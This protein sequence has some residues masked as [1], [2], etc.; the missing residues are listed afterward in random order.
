VAEE[1][2]TITEAA[3]RFGVSTDAV[4]RRARKGDLKASRDNRGQW[5]ILLDPDQPPIVRPPP[6]PADARLAP[7]MAAPARQDGGASLAD[8]RAALDDLRAQLGRA[9]ERAAAAAGQHAAERAEWTTERA[10]L[11]TLIERLT[12][13]ENRAPPLWQ[14]AWVWMRGRAPRP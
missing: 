14:K 8:L 5:W 6:P 11:L 7:A 10:R 1:R 3:T 4:R 2:L 9:E 12:A 13:P